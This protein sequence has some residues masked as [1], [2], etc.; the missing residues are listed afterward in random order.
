L[1]TEKKTESFHFKSFRW[2]APSVVVVPDGPVKHS[3][4]FGERAPD[5]AP[6]FLISTPGHVLGIEH[7]EVLKPHKT[8]GPPERA[9]ERYQDEILS[10]GQELAELRGP[11]RADVTVLFGTTVP[12]T[13][14]KRLALARALEQLVRDRMP[15]DRGHVRL[16]YGDFRGHPINSVDSVH[17][18]REERLT[19][20][21]RW[22]APRAGF[23][24]RDCVPLLQSAID[25]KAAKY[26]SYLKYCDECW[27]LIVAD[28]FKPSAKIHADDKAL[29]HAFTSPFA[30]TFFLDFGLGEL[31]QLK[32]GSSP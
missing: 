1:P 23:V 9:Y 3:D 7:R 16:E 6:D 21:G 11:P 5:G 30:K 19:R 24:W 10:M 22:V 26:N 2:L 15:E 28:S 18:H 8:D 25:D 32:T 20:S 29:A 31:H 27:L 13:R 14:A 12:T 4:T 17:I